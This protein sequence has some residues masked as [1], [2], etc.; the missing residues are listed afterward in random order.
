MCV[1][2]YLWFFARTLF[3]IGG[4]NLYIYDMY[5]GTH[6]LYKRTH[7]SC[8]RMVFFSVRLSALNISKNLA[9]FNVA[10]ETHRRL[11]TS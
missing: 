1:P 9:D 7:W 11:S 5:V 2:M 4:Q 8:F 10:I 6:I 3:H